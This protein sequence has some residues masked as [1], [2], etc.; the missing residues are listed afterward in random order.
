[1]A[2]KSIHANS[3]DCWLKQRE[4]QIKYQCNCLIPNLLFSL[5]SFIVFFFKMQPPSEGELTVTSGILGRI[6]KWKNES[7]VSNSDE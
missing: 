4:K 1:M 6:H 7:T 3:G 5:S 2:I